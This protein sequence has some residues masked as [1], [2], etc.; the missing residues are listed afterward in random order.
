MDDA[1][2]SRLLSDL[3]TSDPAFES[4]LSASAM[5]QNG[6]VGILTDALP[7][8]ALRSSVREAVARL[9]RVS[10]FPRILTTCRGDDDWE[11]GIREFRVF[12]ELN[13]QV[14]V[15]QR[16]AVGGF[17]LGLWVKNVRLANSRKLLSK[18]KIQ[19]LDDLG[20]VWDVHDHL[21]EQ[22]VNRIR[23][24]RA[25]H[26]HVLVP[27]R[28]ETSDGFK[29]GRWVNGKRVALSKG[30]LDEQ[31][32][33]SFDGLGFVW[34]VH[35]HLWEEGITRL[36]QYRAE[37]GHVLVLRGY[38]TSDGF[39]LGHWVNGKRVAKS[40]GKLDEQQIASLDDL[41]FVW[42]V[43][44]HLWEQGITRLRQYRAEHG[45]VLVLRS[46]ETPEG[47]KL[48]DWVNG[49]R[50]AKSKGKLDEQQ[51]ASLDDLGFVWEVNDHL[52]EQGVNRIRQYR[53]EHGHVLVP[54][55]YET[56]DGSKLGRWVNGKRVAKSKGKLDEQQIA[57]L[58]DLGFV[59]NVHDHLWEEG[60]T[61]LRQYRAEHG[62]VLVPWGYETSD[63]FKLG[64]WVNGKRV[65]KSKGKLDEQQIASL[66][67]LGFVWNVYGH[68]WEQGVNRLRQYKA[69]H[70]HVLVPLRYKTP[71]GF[72]LGSWVARKRQSCSRGTLKPEQM[73]CLEDLGFKLG[74]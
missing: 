73:Q 32:I 27:M 44:D 23:Q 24:Y 48:G 56:S 54:W 11:K 45:H 66:F 64:R 42:E 59:W 53:A 34:N 72:K 29:L 15:P 63:G 69:E 68:L 38:E 50:V 41:G 62:H 1:E 67:D 31:Q 10:I 12:K 30:K 14:L 43:N 33:A 9:L 70:G 60:I 4:S 51:I 71:E 61:R 57:S 39:K 55:G 65:A 47:F 13:K 6:H 16:Y 19:L 7:T 37:H 3:A 26:G 2:L 74:V 35:D 18:T 21:W 17:K 22:G 20:F 58:D 8:A 40:K 25:E 49:K 5:G 36:R 46:Y 52:W 28:Y